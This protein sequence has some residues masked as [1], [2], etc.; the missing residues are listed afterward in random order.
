MK[1]ATPRVHRVEPPDLP[2]VRV[3]PKH[4]RRTYSAPLLAPCSRFSTVCFEN[5]QLR[6]PGAAACRLKRLSPIAQVRG[7]NF[8]FAQR[9]QSTHFFLPDRRVRSDATSAKTPTTDV[10]RAAPGAVL[11]FFRQ[12]AWK[13][14]ISAHPESCSLS[15]G[16]AEPHRSG[17]WTKFLLRAAT[18]VHALFSPRPT[19]SL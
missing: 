9:H 17:T 13:I 4:Q 15:I 12:C 19:R 14:D 16:K 7:R 18:P 3:L 10:L 8:C 1:K 5:R 6:S 11:T 2:P